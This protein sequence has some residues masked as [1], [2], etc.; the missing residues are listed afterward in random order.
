MMEMAKYL[1][2]NGRLIDPAEKLDVVSDILISE[3]KI[4]KIGQDIE[5]PGAVI[6]DASGKIISPGL[7]DMHTHLRE[8]GREDKETV[9]TG[10]RAAIH[11]GFTAVACMPN[12]EPAIDRPEACL[13]YTSD[14]AR[15]RG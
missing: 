2:R 10:T 9:Y 12:T 4:K 6:I 13:L 8:P 7:I 5:A 11:G 15:R 3:G 14:A 1:I